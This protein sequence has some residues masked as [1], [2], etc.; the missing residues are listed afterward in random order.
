MH[1][2]HLACYSQLSREPLLWRPY[3][4]T[5]IPYLVSLV[6]TMKKANMFENYSKL[7]SSLM[8]VCMS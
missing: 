1:L 4:W 7:A 3:A 5:M 8:M 2:G 6:T